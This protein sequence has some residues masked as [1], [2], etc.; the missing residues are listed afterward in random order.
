MR[1][2]RR[3]SA[4]TAWLGMCAVLVGLEVPSASARADE[5]MTQEQ[6]GRVYMRVI[7]AGNAARDEFDRKTGANEPY[8]GPAPRSLRWL[9][10]AS[11]DLSPALFTTAR[12][13]H[14]PPSRWPR[15]AEQAVREVAS[16]HVREAVLRARQ[17]YAGDI[18]QWKRLHFRTLKVN[19]RSVRW[20]GKARAILGLPPPGEG[21]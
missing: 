11:R 21:C 7:C 10:L 8:F 5:E 9:R 14:L 4:F 1:V 19:T 15:S 6:A 20:S 3:T 2:F 18:P 12:A 13:L 16:A 17:S